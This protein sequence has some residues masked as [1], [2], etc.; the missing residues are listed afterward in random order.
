MADHKGFGPIRQCR[1]FCPKQRGPAYDGVSGL[2]HRWPPDLV[3]AGEV[4]FRPNLLELGSRGADIAGKCV[5]L[6]HGGIYQDLQAER[7]GDWDDG[8]QRTGVRRDNDPR[9]AFTGELAGSLS[10]LG[11][12]EFCQSGIDDAGIAPRHAKMEIKFALTVAQEDHGRAKYRP[13]CPTATASSG[14]KD[15][16]PG[17]HA[18]I[19]DGRGEL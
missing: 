8:L 3:D 13:V 7:P 18:L 10:G 19:C 16:C 11:V 14:E 2:L 6:T 1:H 5:A 17:P 4:V 9:D 12:T 15:L